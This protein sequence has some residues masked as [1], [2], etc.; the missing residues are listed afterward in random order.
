MCASRTAAWIS[1][2]EYIV[3][4]GGIPG[5]PRRRPSPV[6]YILTTSQPS[7]MFWRTA[8]RTS[9]TPSAKIAR[10]S[11]PSR[12]NEGFQSSIPLVAQMSRPDAASLG[13]KMIPS[14][15]ASRTVTSTRWRAPALA[16]EVY[17]HRRASSAF[18]TA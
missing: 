1:S 16:A 13:P 9:S 2:S 4:S 6:T 3:S 12:Q 7:L 8:L 5:R 15:I 10:P 17:P 18:F 14:S 11:I